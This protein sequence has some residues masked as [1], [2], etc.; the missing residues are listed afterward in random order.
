MNLKISHNDFTNVNLTELNEKELKLFI[1]FCFIL[2]NK[3]IKDVELSFEELK[4]LLNYKDIDDTT[5]IKN[6]TII[7]TKFIELSFRYEDKYKI[8]NFVLFTFFKI[9][10]DTQIATISANESFTQ[11][12]NEIAETFTKKLTI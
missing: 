8:I 6:L 10:K 12:L 2:Q 4:K 9:D 3:A 1:N 11:L 5:F 7:Y